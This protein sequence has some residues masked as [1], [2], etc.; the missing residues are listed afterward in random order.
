MAN[1]YV[2]GEFHPPKPRT[3]VNMKT[4]P[5]LMSPKDVF[6]H[7][8]HTAKFKKEHLYGFY[9]NSKNKLIKKEIIAIGTL[10]GCP[11]GPREVFYP[12]I[13]LC[14]AAVILVHN[15]PSGDPTPSRDDI[16]LTRQIYKA[17]KIMDIDFLDHVIIGENSYIS[18]R[19][20]SP[21]WITKNQF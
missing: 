4:K 5:I 14:A 18:I 9:L 7:S 10:N 17:S 19:E 12:A 13:K 6:Q 15:H 11:S 3:M 16:D 2:M 21:I 20:R 1:K 8:K